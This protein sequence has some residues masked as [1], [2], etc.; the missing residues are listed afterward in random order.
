MAIEREDCVLACLLS[1]V[2]TLFHMWALLRPPLIPGMDGPYYLIQV[3]SILR[4]EGMVY[5]DPPLLFYLS[6]FASILLGDSRLGVSFVTALLCGLSAAPAYLLV[7]FLRDSRVAAVTAGITVAVSPHMVRMACDL[8]KNASGI[9]FILLTV[10]FTHLYLVGGS[11]FCLPIAIASGYLAFLTHSLD[12]AY[13]L[14]YLLSYTIAGTIISRSRKSYALSCLTILIPL[15][16]SSIITAIVLPQYF[17]DVRKGV[18]FL[19]DLLGVRR[20]APIRPPPKPP[21]TPQAPP[22]LL[23]PPPQSPLSPILSLSFMIA[24][25]L[26]LG[27][28]IRREWGTAKP[29]ESLLLSS[30][31]VAGAAGITPTLLGLREW[32]WRFALMELIPVSLIAGLLVSRA[33]DRLA[34]LAISALITITIVA[35]ALW[36]AQGVRPSIPYEGYLDLVELREVIPKNSPYVIHCRISRYWPEYVL[37][38]PPGGKPEYVIECLGSRLPTLR[39]RLVYRGRFLV[40]LR[41]EGH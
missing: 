28:A 3:E 40:L 18:A 23:A 2:S 10:M 37:G 15:I 14:L 26:M 11:G 22:P 1:V 38:W 19:E 33:R 6:A 34:Q 4:G 31:L 13:T 24:G 41:V 30:S 12:Y 17:S 25:I 9:T 27:E 29:G 5:G 39:A 35:Q 20:K 36:M 21:P 16:S 8:M 32:A 7:K